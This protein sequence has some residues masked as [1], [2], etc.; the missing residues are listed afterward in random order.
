MEKPRGWEGLPRGDKQARRRRW[1]KTEPRPVKRH[2]RVVIVVEEKSR[3][4]RRV[5]H[6]L[7]PGLLPACRSGDDKPNGGVAGRN[8]VVAGKFHRQG[9]PALQRSD[10]GGGFRSFLGQRF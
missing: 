2:S 8:G 1:P 10:N 7:S 4:W 5:T 9:F 6:W 3:K